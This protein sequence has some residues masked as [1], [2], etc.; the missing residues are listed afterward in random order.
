MFKSVNDVI[1]GDTDSSND[2][3]EDR[4]DDGDTDGFNDRDADG[5][6][7]SLEDGLDNG[8]TDGSNDADGSNDRDRVG[9]HVGLLDFSSVFVWDVPWLSWASLCIFSSLVVE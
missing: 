7:D 9:R 8:D 6:N 4:L 5:N 1:D 2:G 3:L